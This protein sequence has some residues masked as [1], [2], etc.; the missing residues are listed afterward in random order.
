VDNLTLQ[1]VGEEGLELR[2]LLEPV[3]AKVG[4]S[5]RRLQIIVLDPVSRSLNISLHNINVLD[6][7]NSN[8]KRGQ[9]RPAYISELGSDSFSL[10]AWRSLCMIHNYHA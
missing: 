4:A 5:Q 7:E 9:G 8:R 10:L 3:V 2:V 1:F 6:I